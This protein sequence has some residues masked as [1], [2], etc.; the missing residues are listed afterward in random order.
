MD[1][2]VRMYQAA[3]QWLA[4]MGSDQWAGN[5]EEKARRNITCS[6]KRGE[7]YLAEIDGRP[8]GMITVD[9][10]ADPEFWRP[11][12]QPETALYVHRMVVDRSA[13]GANV[14]GKLLDW[15]NGIAAA[16]G[17]RWLRLDAWRTN[18]QLHAYYERQGFN[19]VRMV[20]LNHRGSG[21]LFQRSVSSS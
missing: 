2:L 9:D 21:A 4:E 18:L 19:V 14:G 17:R 8:V 10:Y 12:D 11:D 7:C 3:R 6:V 20:D 16:R 5:T 1:C 13:S 15:A